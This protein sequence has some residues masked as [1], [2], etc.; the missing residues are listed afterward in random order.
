MGSS[1]RQ[2][3]VPP[4][5][6]IMKLAVVVLLGLFALSAARPSD[7]IDFEVDEGDLELE[8]EQEGIPGTAVEGEYSWTAPNG[9]EYVVKYI[10]DHLGY[11]VL[12]SNA[13]P[14]APENDEEGE[15]APT[16]RNAEEDEDED[17]EEEDEDDE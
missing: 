12:E 14:E 10:A 8:H 11:R 15:D 5:T 16:F 9:E 4:K 2:G 17:E 6:L 3:L 13:I 7:I 1:H